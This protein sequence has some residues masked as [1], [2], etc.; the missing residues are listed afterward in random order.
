LLPSRVAG[1][2]HIDDALLHGLVTWG[3]TLIIGIA[4]LSGAVGAAASGAANL[5]G[6][7]AKTAGQAAGA[8]ISAAREQD[9]RTFITSRIQPSVPR[10]FRPRNSTTPSC[11]ASWI[12]PFSREPLRPCRRPYAVAVGA[13]C[14]CSG[15]ARVPL[16]SGCQS[17]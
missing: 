3:L 5:A 13:Y 8:P 10:D 1:S 6:G 4:L 7:I 2:L 15:S 12:D 14:D 9:L 17:G 11:L 16:E